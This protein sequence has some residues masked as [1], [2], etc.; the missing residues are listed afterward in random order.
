MEKVLHLGLD[1]GSTT[2]K[3]VAL[4]CNDKIIYSKYQ[5][6]FSD[7]KSTIVDVVNEAYAVINDR[8]INVMVT[9]SGGLSVSKWL[10]IPFIQEVIAC[11][12]TIE[13]FIPSTDVAIELGGEDAKITFF[14]GGIDQRMNGTCAGGTGAFIDQM[15]ALLQ[16]DA[17]GLNDLAKNY[18]VIHP[19]AAR[20]GVFAKTD[21][22]PLL[23]EG[24]AREDIAASIFQ[25]VVNQT[26]SGLACGK[27]IKGNVAFL[28]GPLY[29]LSELRNRFIETLN[30]LLNSER[31]CSGPPKN[32]TLPCIGR[33]QARFEIV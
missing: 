6:H 25:A 28:G 19:I 22:Q 14:R 16:T 27:I 10:D 17:A 13:R 30:L 23:N 18:K 3:I 20:C 11:T 4:D 2:I 1:I 12:N 5:R 9:G 24:A 32:A 15:A 29:F 21:I 31:K 8:N 26:I 33:P 7:I